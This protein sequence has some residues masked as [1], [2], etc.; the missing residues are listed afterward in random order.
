MHYAIA[1]II[2][3]ILVKMGWRAIRPAWREGCLVCI[4]CI[5][6]MLEHEGYKM[7]QN[8]FMTTKEEIVSRQEDLVA[9]RDWVV[10]EERI[11][12]EVSLSRR[13]MA[14]PLMIL[15]MLRCIISPSSSTL[16][17]SSS[18]A[19]TCSRWCGADWRGLGGA[20]WQ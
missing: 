6:F 3:I 14:H 1:T 13:K 11:N 9:I 15:S 12:V 16:L 2:G 17:G 19:S 8:E 4:A 7:L 18:A 10:A 5:F 20:G